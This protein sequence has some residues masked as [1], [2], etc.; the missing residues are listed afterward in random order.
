MADSFFKGG[1]NNPAPYNSTHIR[2]PLEIKDALE[3]IIAL[4]KRSYNLQATQFRVDLVSSLK[5]FSQTFLGARSTLVDSKEFIPLEKYKELEDKFR[6]ANSDAAFQE[7][8]NEELIDNA[9]TAKAI[10]ES[11][12]NLK[13]NSGG[14][15]KKE[16]RKAIAAL[17]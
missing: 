6:Q 1:R 10:L 16:I 5:N 7:S 8:L 3:N 2:V 17:D 13:A 14:A 15:I 12:C 4:Y 9:N 11:C